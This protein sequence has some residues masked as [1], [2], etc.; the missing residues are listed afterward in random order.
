MS[1]AMMAAL[2]YALRRAEQEAAL[3][4]AAGQPEAAAAHYSLCFRHSVEALDILTASSA[5][6]PC[7]AGKGN[8]LIEGF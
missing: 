8:L 1:E 6:G 4:I 2:Y 3:S 5:N 7:A